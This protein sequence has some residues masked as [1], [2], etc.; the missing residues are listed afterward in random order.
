MEDITMKKI[1]LLLDLEDLK[2]LTSLGKVSI[3]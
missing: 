1:A 3:A 2:I